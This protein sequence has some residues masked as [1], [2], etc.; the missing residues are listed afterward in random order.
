M[1]IKKLEL[2][3]FKSFSERTRILF[4]P[5]ITA[6][7]GPNGTGKSNIVDGMLWT[8][9][10][11]R[12]RSQR[13]ESGGDYI[14]NGNAERAPMSM[15]DV[16]VIL[17]EDKASDREDLVIN[18]R[19]FRSGESEYRLGGK[20]CRLKDIQE[21]L[22]RNGIGDTDY[23][24]IEQGSIGLFLTSKPVEKRVLLEEAA[25]TAYYKDK[26][27]QAQNK[28]ESSEQN[29]LRLE[30]I[31]LEVEKA[32]G[33]L[34]RQAQAA[35]RYRKL[36]EHIR[37][38]T[39]NLFRRKI[40]VLEDRQREAARF[41]QEK[42]TA[43]RGL[44]D[45]IK[46]EE[47]KLA[48]RRREAYEEEKRLKRKQDELYAL[49]SQLSQTEAE[50][51]REERRLD[52][53]AEKRT[54]AE[55]DLNELSHEQEG[56]D[57]EAAEVRKAF[58]SLQERL[59]A[60]Q[61]SLEAAEKDQKSSSVEIESREQRIEEFRKEYLKILA[62]QTEAKNQAARCE[63]ELELTTRQQDRLLREVH[64]QTSLLE[65]KS[66][67]LKKGEAQLQEICREIEKERIKLE[68]RQ[69]KYAVLERQSE[70]QESRRNAL[71]YELNKNLHHLHALEK[72]KDQEARSAELPE[73]PEAMGQ[74]ADFIEGSKEHTVLIDVFYK[75]EAKAV[76]VRARDLLEAL[77]NESLKG[78]FLL[79]HPEKHRPSAPAVY[80]DSRVV[81]ML[82]AHIQAQESLKPQLSALQDAAIVR[83]IQDAVELW[84]EHPLN[85][86]I[87]L[88]GDLL[89]SSGLLKIGEK[90]DGLIALNRDI[91]LLK[92]DI[93]H[94]EA[95]LSPLDTEFE[96]TMQRMES[97]RRD[98]L[99]TNSRLVGLEQQASAEKKEV[100]LV[101]G[102]VEQSRAQ[103]RLLEDE[104][105][106]TADEK[107][108][109]TR[110]WSSLTSRIEEFKTKEKELNTKI[111][112]EE[113]AL[114][115]QR[116]RIEQSRRSYFQFR[117]EVNLLQEKIDNS[118]ALLKRLGERRTLVHTK[119]SDLEK[120][121]QT[122]DRGRDELR[123]RLHALT[124]LAGRLSRD[125]QARQSRLAEEE[126]ELVRRQAELRDTEAAIQ[127]L[128]DRLEAAEEERVKWE[129]S[130]AE[131]ERDLVNLEES[132]WQEIKKTLQ[133]IKAEVPQQEIDVAE[134]EASLE[135]VKEKLQR[136]SAV[137]L[138][139]EEEYLAQK[140]R[141]DFLTR[142]KEDLVES[143]ASSKEAIKKIDQEGR[144]Q[145]LQ[146]LIEI[147][148]NFQDV[149][150][151]LFQGGTAQLKLSDEDNPLESGIEI[152]AQPPGKRVQS[153]N[154]LS[155]GEKSLTSLAF[156]FALFRYRPAPFCILDEV[157][158]A[159]D[160]TNLT[161][162]LN[163][164][165][166]I[167]DQTQF[168]IITHNFKT[169]EVADYIYGTTMAE[170]NITSLYSV[171]LKP[172][173]RS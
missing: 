3:G 92:H 146:A 98:M 59:E 31:I 113:E 163:L 22:H 104:A 138:M 121:L 116:E 152:T 160:E 141:L 12:L 1:I 89:L 91:K 44:I 172:K 37:G 80:E 83:R 60:Q 50:K 73:L 30:D 100:S 41:H 119:I 77:G 162:F 123:E 166:N 144:T 79:L 149:F 74:L 25:G 17:G 71:R 168:I 139:A 36:R 117:S 78:R 156:F 142:Q 112:Q 135:K 34:K 147:N 18:H 49:K 7:I 5:G 151:Q 29:L 72:L 51:D 23:F 95:E 52:F 134:A 96:E 118:R 136:I 109:I 14:F 42:F 122:T 137:N 169:M 148:K 103:T 62:E 4:H 48:E 10:G 125:L 94:R 171:K 40:E 108:N 47:K 101:T 111:R 21:E 13:V 9:R 173:A 69:E 64:D 84:I 39:L 153:L 97:L 161:R 133:E 53:F 76:L 2:H 145:F 99:E 106:S 110:E 140:K 87:T 24:V 127:Q 67:R 6:V 157:D 19:L 105:S 129:V 165:H 124:G 54:G 56:L 86:Y 68:D 35:I 167:K 143:I 150:A 130:K 128:R 102:I 45:R 58:E 120:E 126:A 154:L 32:T 81:G 115:G 107:Q 55:T 11:R 93:A 82:K 28:L 158:A 164:M 114:S 57:R 131:R 15:A 26:K 75:E 65:E 8:L 155:G 27:R 85:N 70:A 170:P 61:K 159:L 33:S 38:L 20:S 46:A 16:S 88:Q 43:E 132:C 90:K 66:A 63:K